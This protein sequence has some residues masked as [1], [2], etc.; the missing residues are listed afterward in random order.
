[1]VA[2][3][4]RYATTLVLSCL[5]LAT[6]TTEIIGPI[7]DGQGGVSG[8][9]RL[10]MHPTRNCALAGTRHGTTEEYRQQN[11]TEVRVGVL[12]LD[13]LSIEPLVGA[14]MSSATEF[15]RDHSKSD[16]TTDPA[17]SLI[18]VA[19]E[20]L[21]QAVEVQLNTKITPSER[22]ASAIRRGLIM[23]GQVLAA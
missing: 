18:S 9:R 6:N 16:W 21:A 1:M 10:R 17:P 3:T 15:E 11:G 7:T 13:S 14:F 5:D 12:D 23:S 2:I 8:V 20:L 4:Q 19:P 22:T